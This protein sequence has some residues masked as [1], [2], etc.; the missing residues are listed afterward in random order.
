M[1]SLSPQHCPDVISRII[2]W[3][4]WKIIR[5]KYSFQHWIISHQISY[6]KFLLC[7]SS[8]ESYVIVVW[9]YIHNGFTKNLVL[10]G[11]NYDSFKVIMSVY[12]YISVY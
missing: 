1:S 7:L 9:V 4:Y 2:L 6:R 8:L 5:Q 12:V 11:I 3:S 10:V